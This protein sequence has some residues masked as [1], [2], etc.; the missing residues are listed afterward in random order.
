MAQTPAEGKK[1]PRHAKP[2]ERIG[3]KKKAIRL[4]FRTSW[5]VFTPNFLGS[6]M[7][8]SGKRAIGGVRDIQQDEYL[9][10]QIR[11]RGVE[12]LHGMFGLGE[13]MTLGEAEQA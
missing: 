13:P 1:Q 5:Y 8:G 2:L 7:T 11:Q 9:A 4:A 6:A 10:L 3:I 12:Q